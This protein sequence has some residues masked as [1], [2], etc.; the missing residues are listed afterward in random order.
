MSAESRHCLQ[1][2][3]T[4]AAQG[5]PFLEIPPELIHSVYSHLDKPAI[6]TTRLTCSRLVDIGAE[7]LLEPVH[8]I[9][10]LERFEQPADIYTHP[11]L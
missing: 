2:A 3:P 1:D 9:Y 11:W 7:H 8:L 10:K 5:S 6:E 4:R